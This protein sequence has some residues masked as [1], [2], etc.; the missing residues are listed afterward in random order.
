MIALVMVLRPRK[1]SPRTKIS[2]HFPIIWAASLDKEDHVMRLTFPFILGVKISSAKVAKFNF[3]SSYPNEKNL[4][5]FFIVSS[6]ST[7]KLF[8]SRELKTKSSKSSETPTWSSFQIHPTGN[9]RK[10][11]HTGIQGFIEFYDIFG[12]SIFIK[13]SLYGNTDTSTSCSHIIRKR[14][15]HHHQSH[16][17]CSYTD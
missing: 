5:I 14:E 4:C 15:Q 10:R 12:F 8:R 2:T 9:E 16:L 17:N 13:L 3:W 1:A 7:I 11:I 6:C